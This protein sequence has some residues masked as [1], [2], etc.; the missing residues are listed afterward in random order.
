MYVAEIKGKI[1]S[2]ITRLEDVLTSNVF[3]FLKYSNRE[4]YLAQFLK[5]ILGNKFSIEDI[6]DVSF[7]FWKQYDDRTEPDLVI[8][9][10][11]GK[12]ILIEA[13]YLS[14]FGETQPEREIHYGKNE[15]N[16]LGLE[17]F[18]VVVTNE[19]YFKEDRYRKIS[20]L[21]NNF[22]WINWQTI[23][24]IIYD[25]IEQDSNPYMAEDLFLLAVKKNLRGFYG[26]DNVNHQ[27]LYSISG[28][29]LNE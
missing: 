21:V 4:V 24:E 11:G 28:R 3:S 16:S 26:F 22:A 9:T 25:N 13:K 20:S 18:Y 27:K 29:W 15:A 1:P 8:T 23:F 5:R 12:Y 19:Y 17:F 7:E 14:D 2:K 10:G 6:E